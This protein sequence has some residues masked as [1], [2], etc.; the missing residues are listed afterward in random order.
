MTYS[1]EFL[2]KKNGFGEWSICTKSGNTILLF[3]A[4]CKN[5]AIRYANAWASSW[6]SS[7]MEVADEKQEKRD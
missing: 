7:R 5:E 6:Q 3:K 1:Y 2:L 4:D